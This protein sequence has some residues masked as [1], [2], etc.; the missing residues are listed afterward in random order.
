MSAKRPEAKY[1]CFTCYDAECPWNLD[2]CTYVVYGREICPT[3]GK[4]HLQGFVAFEK[5]T[6]LSA[7]KKVDPS[8][9]YEV[10]RGTIAEAVKYCKKD[11]DF[12]ELGDLPDDNSGIAVRKCI[13]YARNGDMDA[14]EDLSPSL[15]LRYKRTFDGL[16][17]FDLPMLTEPTG[18]WIYGLP[19]TSKDSNVM[20]LN[21][22]VKSHNKWW[23]GYTG[24]KY[25]L[26]SDVDTSTAKWI[27][28]FLKI[29]TDMY[30]FNAEYKG[31]V[32]KIRPERVYV[33]SNYSL[34]ALFMDE[35][36]MLKALERRFHVIDFDNDIVKYR[37]VIDH[38]DK[39][40]LIDF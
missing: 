27:G 12:T 26:I 1:W 30:P 22:F 10:K 21:P 17:K 6:R 11:G 5:K 20:K 15:F 38:V 32:M 4:P 33:T 8:G 29:W 23:D 3:T 35:P 14:I 16:R 40:K 24:Q 39:I 36:Q 37:P 28:N 2:N 25:V 19:G 31:G 9:H 7:I 34:K 13:E 18:Y